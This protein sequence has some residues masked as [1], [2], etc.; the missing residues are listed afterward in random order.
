[1]NDIQDADVDDEAGCVNVER[2]RS[3]SSTSSVLSASPQRQTVTPNAASVGPACGGQTSTPTGRGFDLLALQE[4]ISLATASSLRF[5]PP[6]PPPPAV[7]ELLRYG[8]GLR[9]LAAAPPSSAC[10][11]R[12]SGWTYPPSTS[13]Y[14][15]TA[16]PMEVKAAGFASQQMRD[17][18]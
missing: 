10:P 7:S 1:M 18:R 11:S 9:G 15:L 8:P 16:Q 13:R 12:S 2:R 6:P 17:G 14:N 3:S 4:A 5:G